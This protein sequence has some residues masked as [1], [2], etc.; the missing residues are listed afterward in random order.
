MARRSPAVLSLLVASLLLPSAHPVQAQSRS[1]PPENVTITPGDGTLTVT[2]TV[3]TSPS[4]AENE[5]RHALRWSQE[6]GVWA[7]PAGP[8][9]SANDGIVIPAGTSSYTITGLVNDV[10]TGVFLR[11]FTGDSLSEW[12]D[13]SSNWVRVKGVE[14]TPTATPRADTPSLLSSDGTLISLSLSAGSLKP[15]FD[16]VVTEY[17]LDVESA[18]HETT[19]TATV[20]DTGKAT[21]RATVTWQGDVLSEASLTSG[22]AGGPFALGAGENVIEIVV[23]AED[24]TT[25][26]YTVTVTRATPEVQAQDPPAQ[27]RTLTVTGTPACGSNSLAGSVSL[28]ATVQIAPAEAGVVI[29]VQLLLD[30]PQL[31]SRTARVWQDISST[32]SSTGALDWKV[33]LGFIPERTYTAQFRIKD[34]PTVTAQCSWTGAAL[35]GVP[36]DVTVEAGNG[37]LKVTWRAPTSDGGA[38]IITYR[39]RWRTGTVWQYAPGGTREQTLPPGIWQDEDGNNDNGEDVGKVLAYTISDL[40][41]R[42]SYDVQVA[43]VTVAGTGEFA[44]PIGEA[45]GTPGHTYRIDDAT[46]FEGGNADLTI[47]LG[48]GAPPNG[49]VF[50]ITPTYDS[51]QGKASAADV[52]TVPSSVTVFENQKTATVTIPLLRD[53]ISDDGETFTV[54]ISANLDDWNPL[55]TGADSA[56]VTIVDATPSFSITAAVS[57]SEGDSA[58]LTISLSEDAPSGGVSFSVAPKFTTGTGKAVAADVGTVSSPVKVLEDTSSLMITVPTV[59]DSLDEDSETFGVVISTSVSGWVKAGDGKDTATV[60]INDDDTAGFTVTPTSLDIGEGASGTY[61]IVLDSQPAHS[62]VV[63]LTNP[64]SGAVTVS[65]SSWTFTTTNWSTAKTFTVSGVEENDDFSDETVT[66]SHSVTSSDT[67]YSGLTPDSVT[68][69]VD[70][71]DEA[72]SFSITAA[73]SVSEGDSASLTISLSEDAPSG[74]VSFSVAPKFTTGTGKAVAADVGTVSSPVKVL[75]DTSSLMITVPTVEDSLDEDSETFGVV[76][77]TSV[78]GWVKAGDGKDTATVTINDDDT[79]GFTV[80][81]TSL[82]IGEGASGTYTIVLDSQPAHSVV[83]SLTNPDSGAV[84]VSP[85]SWTFTTTNWSTAKTFTV[86][87]VEENDDFS[88][89]T[90]TISHSVTSSDTKYSGFDARFGDGQRRRQRRDWR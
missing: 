55:E 46:G 38:P 73:V 6:T 20:S 59:E 4:V 70:D 44:P 48:T 18:V 69:N 62:V 33:Q 28:S 79:A 89:E 87:G 88:D 52:G 54:A 26:T 27:Q 61:T 32:T 60:T 24:A 39:V 90:V 78:S 12:S 2:W 11:S 82:D 14:T 76:I 5:I 57:V 72:P 23:T 1:P 31:G 64:D 75:E 74:G 50:T 35:P 63:S 71:N 16:P 58:S 66:I 7:N 53:A 80:T 43:A 83:V 9:A 51:G 49:V 19:M 77:S 68:V 65:P 30:D 37:R 40:T 21:A 45:T 85:S 36:T 13:R 3:T 47:T 41:D 86:S 25:R 42:V 8:T 15:D 22:E 34:D 10:A 67:K 29:Q 81:P 84:T 56:T 17:A